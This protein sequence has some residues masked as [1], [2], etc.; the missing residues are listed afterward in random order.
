MAQNV[1][2]LEQSILTARAEVDFV[3]VSGRGSS[4]RLRHRSIEDH[5]RHCGRFLYGKLVPVVPEELYKLVALVRMTA[6]RTLAPYVERT[7]KEY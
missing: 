4:V 5:S 7:A 6:R 1:Q 3:H 2:Y